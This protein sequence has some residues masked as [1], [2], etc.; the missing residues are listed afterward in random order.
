[1][2]SRRLLFDPFRTTIDPRGDLETRQPAPR[3]IRYPSATS[4]TFPSRRDHNRRGIRPRAI[5]A[6]FPR[7]FPRRGTVLAEIATT[8]TTTT[9]SRPL[10]PTHSRANSPPP[11]PLSMLGPAVHGLCSGHSPPLDDTLVRGTFAG[12]LVSLLRRA[13]FFLLAPS[14]ATFDRRQRQGSPS[15]R[16]SH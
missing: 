14:R 3:R 10:L 9:E 13:H 6:A 15:A 2:P 16:R 8:T 5:G 4:R 12:E 1:M 11:R 7:R